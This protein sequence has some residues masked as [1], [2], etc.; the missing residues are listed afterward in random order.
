[1]KFLKDNPELK[2]EIDSHTDSRG[3]AANNLKLSQARAQEVVNYLQKNGI[4]KA[5]LIAKGYGA[6]RLVNGCKV[7]V[8]CTDAQNEQNRRTEFK[9]I[10]K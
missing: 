8:K 2:I 7:G 9:V 1:M 3:S 5:R 10:D 4:D 6:T